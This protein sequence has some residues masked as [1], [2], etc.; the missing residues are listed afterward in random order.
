MS[1]LK[2]L[3]IAQELLL[4]PKPALWLPQA[5]AIIRPIEK[6]RAPLLA[7]TLL[8]PFWTGPATGPQ[9]V[10]GQV[11]STVGTISDW[12][13]NFALTGGLAATPADGDYVIVAYAIAFNSDR[14]VQMTTSGYTSIG[15][16][17]YSNDASDINAEV[18]AKFMSGTP[19]TS[20]T[21]FQ[22]ESV[23]AA[24]AVHISVWRGVNVTTQMDV[25]A[26]VAS[27]ID[28]MLADP[29]S[30]TPVTSGAKIVAIG[31]TNPN[32]NTN[33]YTSGDLTDF[34]SVNQAD[35]LRCL[36]G[37]G[38]ASWAGGAF[39]PA[40]FTIAGSDSTACAWIAYTFALRPA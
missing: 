29:G 26:V 16:D 40:A 8:N 30:I 19:D 34:Q 22:T 15:A 38:Y 3:A 5:P 24:G 20:V 28:T 4:P 23:Q 37:G 7:G 1:L 25:A 21:L 6:Q 17:T 12:P 10:G 11:A 33:I 18:F 14:D 32:T 27:G 31:M 13:V 39:D 2:S 9:Y 36:I 35:T